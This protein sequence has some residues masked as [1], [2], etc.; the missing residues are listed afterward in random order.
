MFAYYNGEYHCV[1]C[2]GTMIKR[3]E[4]YQCSNYHN[5]CK[6]F[7]P[8][9]KNGR[10]ISD[11]QMRRLMLFG[12]T[13][14]MLDLINSKGKRFTGKI[15]FND[16]YKLI[17]VPSNGVPGLYCPKCRSL[18]IHHHW[19]YG[20]SSYREN[21]CA[22]KIC[23]FGKT[24]QNPDDIRRLLNGHKVYLTGLRRYDNDRRYNAWV[25][26]NLDENSPGFGNIY[27]DKNV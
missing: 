9:N 17:Q 16:N 5:G 12:E 20:C 22:F 8:N 13:D 6:T 1:L 7:V 4:G 19:G 25:R 15:M 27:I 26:L 11:A 10:R 23:H 18:L 3:H 24:I 2:K 14:E 21:G